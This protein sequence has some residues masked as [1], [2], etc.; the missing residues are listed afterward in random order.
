MA[1]DKAGN[2]WYDK[3]E[4][5]LKSFSIFNSQGKFEEASELFLKAANSCKMAKNCTL[6]FVLY[7]RIRTL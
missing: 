1:D 2:D 7:C 6:H 3:A 5:K 4:K